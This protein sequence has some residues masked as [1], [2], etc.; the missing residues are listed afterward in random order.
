MKNGKTHLI[1]GTIICAATMLLFLAFNGSLPEN[2]PLQI[3]DDGSVGNSLPKS[4][5]VFG[6]PVIFVAVN[7]I[8]SIPLT[9]KQDASAF[10]FYIIPGIAV[11]LSI[12]ILC[13]ALGA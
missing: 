3:T 12:A 11:L 10:G 2:V 4:L 5:V 1:I 6:L 8:R 13:M 7:L 9:R